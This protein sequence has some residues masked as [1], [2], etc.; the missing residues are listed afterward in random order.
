RPRVLL[1]VDA[2]WWRRVDDEQRVRG[3]ILAELGL[4][5]DQLMLSL[6]H[7]H[8][9]AVLCTSDAH[10]PGGELIPGYVEA[11]TAAAIE[12]GREALEGARPGLIEWATGSCTLAAD[13]E[14]VL[15][16]RALVGYNP[17]GT[18]DDTVMIGRITRDGSTIATL[19]NYACHP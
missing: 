6:S 8:A 5:V 7:T 17:A 2:T 4:E 13:R 9:G 18:A 14:L 1:A 10:L 19:V 11:L 12:A 3:A 15:E 16:G